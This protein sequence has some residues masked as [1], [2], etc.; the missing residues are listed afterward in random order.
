ME[1]DGADGRAHN[2]I[3]EHDRVKIVRRKAL[4]HGWAD[5]AKD[6]GFMVIPIESEIEHKEYS[7]GSKN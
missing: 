6:L 4:R 5:I 7:H 3:S 2:P 1:A